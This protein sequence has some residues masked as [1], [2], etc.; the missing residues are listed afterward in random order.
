VSLAGVVYGL[1]PTGALL[2][3]SSQE[4]YDG[5]VS[6]VR[7]VS[8]HLLVQ[9]TFPLGD[10]PLRVTGRVI[11]DLDAD[12]DG[13]TVLGG[14]APDLALG[15]EVN[16]R[17]G[18]ALG[19]LRLDL[20][21]AAASLFLDASG[22]VYFSG[23]A[24]PAIFG[25]TSL[26]SFE[27]AGPL[28]VRA[29][30]RSASDFAVLLRGDGRLLGLPFG[31]AEVEL[32]ST[33]V[34]IRGRLDLAPV[35]P[36]D[37]A[38]AVAADGSWALAGR[39][40][41]VTLGGVPLRDVE[42]MASPRG[43]A[44]S[45]ANTTFLGRPFRVTGWVQPGGAIALTGTVALTRTSRVQLMLDGRGPRASF[46]GQVCAGRVCVSVPPTEI[47]AQGNVCASFP[48]VGRQCVRVM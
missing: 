48:L 15:G 42:V 1:S 47:D 44:I 10:L 6:A 19:P 43:V 30:Y 24:P 5:R 38:G 27:P 29:V 16:V 12:D 22:A 25:G 40:P 21:V 26:S 14:D 3:A 45:G 2:H 18:F 20:E 39:A 46:E 32:A 36:V 28:V 8:G 13:V 4:L 7:R 41:D 11:A 23:S 31:A 34:Q 9:G 17:A 33:R 37:V 35:G